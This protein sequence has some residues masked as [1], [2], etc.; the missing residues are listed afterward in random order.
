MI[1]SNWGSDLT[2]FFKAAKEGGLNIN[3]FTMNA[4]NPGTPAE[5]G[6]WGAEKVGVIWN[7]GHNAPTPELE[8]TYLAYKAKYSEDFIF[9]AHWNSLSMLSAAVQ[10]AGTVEPKK[11]AYALEGMKYKSPIGEV[12]MRK[13]DHQL[14]APLFLGIWAKQGSKGVKYD[15]EKTG[16]G[17]RSEVVWDSYI[18]AQPTSC[19][20]A[21][22]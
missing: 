18:S 10:K 17:F 2:L 20:M 11:V 5:M 8:K 13:T 16:Y 9:A 15:A 7:W 3:F 4:N 12:E 6:S 1:T 22:P 19:Q 14:L 21:R